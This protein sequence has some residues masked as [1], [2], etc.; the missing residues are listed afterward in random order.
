MEPFAYEDSYKIE[1]TFWWFAGRRFF[2]KRIFE[3]FLDKSEN[4]LLLDAWC[5]SGGTLE[6]LRSFGTTIGIDLS[7]DALHFCK[8]N[9][10]GNLLQGDINH[11]PIK[12]KR[13]DCVVALDL[14]EHLE[15]ETVCLKEFHRILKPG[16]FLI[17]F[18]PAY[19]FMWSYMDEIG[20]HFRRYSR[21]DL[22]E[23]L[24]RSG[25]T[26]KWLSS[27]NL[28]LFPFIFAARKIKA[29]LGGHI[30]ANIPSD[31]KALPEFQNYCFTKLMF[32][33]GA[34][35]EIS[36]LPFGLSFICVSQK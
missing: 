15:D 5:G 35:S 32:L 19:Q 30:T 17:T 18:V 21:H 26:L 34:I 9:N 8:K 3:R 1:K 24:S 22:C 33:E 7:T 10:L 36:P 13:F 4:L 25:Y 14:L 23:V 31:V 16:G 20:H 27:F 6:F 29:L 11:L 28:F 12:S 2:L